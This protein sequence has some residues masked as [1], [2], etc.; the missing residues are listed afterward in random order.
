MEYKEY[1][2][3]VH[4][5]ETKHKTLES[6]GYRC[7]VCRADQE[8]HVHHLTYENIGHEKRKDLLVLC[9]ICH[10]KEHNR[11]FA[12]EWLERRGKIEDS[13]Y[14]GEFTEI[15]ESEGQDGKDQ[16]DKP[17]EWEP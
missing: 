1:L 3:S 17:D 5:Q 9:E 16:F 6:A 8:L 12:V 14:H 15:D 11:P 10:T 2:K 4:W 13:N 7:E